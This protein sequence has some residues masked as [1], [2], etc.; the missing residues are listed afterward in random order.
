MTRREGGVLRGATRVITR[1]LVSEEQA[2]EREGSVEVEVAET[3]DGD[4]EDSQLISLSLFS[5]PP[6]EEKERA[7]LV[8]QPFFSSGRELSRKRASLLPSN[9]R[10]ER[11]TRQRENAERQTPSAFVFFSPRPSSCTALSLSQPF[12]ENGTCLAPDRPLGAAPGAEAPAGGELTREERGKR[13]NERE[14]GGGHT[15]ESNRCA[16]QQKIEPHSTSSFLSKNPDSK[17]HT[18]SP[19]SPA[20]P[21]AVSGSA[22]ACAPRS[23]SRARFAPRRTRSAASGPATIRRALKEG[24][25]CSA[26]GVEGPRPKWPWTRCSR[27][28][29]SRS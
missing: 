21:T 3:N 14:E 25:R 27:G 26:R 15:R 12:K 1:K 11:V 23:G 20:P 18:S 4:D 17:P 9:G 6:T 8:L 22:S 24:A 10:R 7:L 2:G 5:S 29:S 13:E 16:Q 28:G 19:S